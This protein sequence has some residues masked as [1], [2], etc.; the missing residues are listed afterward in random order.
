MSEKAKALAE[1]DSLASYRERLRQGGLIERQYTN[2]Y[3]P[4]R[5][6]RIEANQEKILRLLKFLVVFAPYSHYTNAIDIT[7]IM[8]EGNEEEK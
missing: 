5:L 7:D 4:D 6:D 3:P 1:Q 8:E 2:Y